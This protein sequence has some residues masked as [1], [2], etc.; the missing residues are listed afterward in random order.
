MK[1]VI[2]ILSKLA[3]TVWI[4]CKII[5]KKNDE[6][7]HNKTSFRNKCYINRHDSLIYLGV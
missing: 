4:M 5:Q 2:N 7:G 1:Y 3:I 6:M